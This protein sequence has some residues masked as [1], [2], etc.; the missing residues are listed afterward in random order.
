MKIFKEGASFGIAGL[1]Q[2][3]IDWLV[4]VT[5][6]KFGVIAAAANMLGRVSGA[7]VGFWLNGKWTFRDADRARLEHRH[8]GRYV[9]WWLTTALVSTAAVTA[10]AHFASVETSWAAKPFIDAFLAACSF[11]VSKYWIYR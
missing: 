3:G 2:L 10:I 1:I 6:T 7:S 5:L 8:L 11:F 4:F 9:V